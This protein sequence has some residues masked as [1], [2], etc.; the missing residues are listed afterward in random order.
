MTN[1]EDQVLGKQR[2]AIR[3]KYDGRS[4]FLVDMGLK[5][6]LLGLVAVAGGFLFNAFSDLSL[7]NPYSSRGAV[8][9]YHKANDT[10]ELLQEQR[11]SLATPEIP[12]VSDSLRP[13]LD[14]IF[15]VDSERIGAISEATRIVEADISALK[16]TD[17]FKSYETW[18]ESA[19]KYG[20]RTMLGGLG[21]A[22]LPWFPITYFQRRNNRRRDEELEQIKAQNSN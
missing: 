9:Q 22:V 17:D 8:V 2:S 11:A 16:Q 19:E 13:L 1:E 6:S 3:S 20:S 4:Y 12:Y 14:D 15:V 18:P 21:L 7:F 10:L 5:G